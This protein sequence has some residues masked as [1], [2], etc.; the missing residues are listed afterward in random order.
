MAVKTIADALRK[1]GEAKGELKGRLNGKQETLILQLQR[2]FGHRAAIAV[3][4]Q[5][6]KTK[7][8]QLLDEWLGRVIDAE[9]LEE[10]GILK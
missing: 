10:I 3:A 7:D 1:E 6:Q 2:K 9:T 5:I 8:D 4:A